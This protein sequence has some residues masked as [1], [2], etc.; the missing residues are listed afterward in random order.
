MR[1]IHSQ[2][3]NI[4][5]KNVRRFN[6][7]RYWT[8]LLAVCMVVLVAELAYFSWFFLDMAKRLDAPAVPSLETN[9]AKIRRME[10]TL[11]GVEEGIRTRTGEGL[12]PEVSE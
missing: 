7:H 5:L 8:L 4:P 2:Q 3:K 12:G 10:R 11:R 6:P 9:A 1:F